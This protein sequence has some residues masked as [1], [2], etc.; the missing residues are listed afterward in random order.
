[1]LKG[2]LQDPV[3]LRFVV[4]AVLLIGWYFGHHAPAT[5][6]ILATS[7]RT[8][9]EKRRIATAQQ[10]ERL[11]KALA[12]FQSRIP[13]KEGQN[14][15]IQY[16]MAR[17]R[18]SPLKLVDLNPGRNDDLGSVR[19]IELT[20]KLEGSYADLDE[21]LN[22]VEHEHRLLRVDALKIQRKGP[23]RRGLAIEMDLL[24]L[25]DAPKSQAPEKGATKAAA[26]T[27]D[28]KK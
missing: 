22:W 25:V 24:G 28:E 14:E 19:A 1:L 23:Q 16:V 13:R 9:A 12:P 20:L 6:H 18:R 11:R 15:M 7:S 27:K 2:Q 17:V 10:V 3:R 8:E 4:C 5:E 26:R 21:F